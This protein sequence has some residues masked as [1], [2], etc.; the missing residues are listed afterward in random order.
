MKDLLTREQRKEI[1]NLNNLSEFEFTSYCNLSDY[2]IEVINRHQRDHNRLGFAL[3][4][5]KRLPW[6]PLYYRCDLKL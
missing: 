1:L 5:V 2:D 3:P 4:L 6:Q